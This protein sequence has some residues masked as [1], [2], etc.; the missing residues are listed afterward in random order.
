MSMSI[1]SVL[2]EVNSI[3]TKVLNSLIKNQGDTTEAEQLFAEYLSKRYMFKVL[4]DTTKAAIRMEVEHMNDYIQHNYPAAAQS[5]NLTHFTTVW[6]DDVCG[7]RAENKGS[8]SMKDK[9]KQ[10]PQLQPRCSDQC[11]HCIYIEEGDFLC[12]VV[13]DATIVGWKPFPCACPKKRRL[14]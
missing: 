12:D 8:R 13:Q 7:I 14:N 9:S 6:I 1:G 10:K 4:T 3:Y 11:E 2:V 5:G